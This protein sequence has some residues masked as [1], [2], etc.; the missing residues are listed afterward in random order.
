VP[1]SIHHHEPPAPTRWRLST[2]IWHRSVACLCTASSFATRPTATDYD[3]AK[4]QSYTF[5][6]AWASISTSLRPNSRLVHL[7]C[8]ICTDACSRLYPAP[9]VWCRSFMISTLWEKLP[10]QSPYLKLVM[11]V[12]DKY[13]RLSEEQR[14]KRKAAAEE[15]LP[16]ESVRFLHWPSRPLRSPPPRP[17]AI[18]LVSST[19]TLLSFAS[20]SPFR[21]LGHQFLPRSPSLPG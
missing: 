13:Q 12:Y 3:E 14:A 10:A 9:R 19:S 2:L 20:H 6:V 8:R 5:G 11:D 1:T 21:L 4:V 17:F 16:R 15:H 18:S 7:F